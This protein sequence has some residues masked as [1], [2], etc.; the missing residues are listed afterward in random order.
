[1]EN[2]MKLL[3]TTLLFALLTSCVTNEELPSEHI[4]TD[5]SIDGRWY[6]VSR[7]HMY[8]DY[9]EE[10]I[11]GKQESY[12]FSYSDSLITYYGYDSSDILSD[13]GESLIENT[14]FGQVTNRL[15]LDDTLCFI[16][17]KGEHQYREKALQLENNWSELAWLYDKYTPIQDTVDTPEKMIGTWYLAYKDTVTLTDVPE[18]TSTSFSNVDE[19]NAIYRITTDSVTC[20]T[21]QGDYK[22]D[23]VNTFAGVH[24]F[25]TQ[26]TV[27]EDSLIITHFA[28][29]NY[30]NFITTVLIKHSGPTPP[31]S[32]IIEPYLDKA[33]TLNINEPE[34]GGFNAPSD[35]K[36]Y[37]FTASR[38]GVYSL[39]F[40]NVFGYAQLFTSNDNGEEL[41]SDFIYDNQ[42]IDVECEKGVTYYFSLR[43][44]YEVMS[45]Y[46]LELTEK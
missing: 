37:Q 44:E 18:T 35:G 8:K 20:F 12:V 32:W 27:K 25:I 11:L 46:T 38:N 2:N 26:G 14:F 29:N 24:S 1:M 3:L 13:S 31:R 42:S 22:V 10:H 45:N 5:K 19:S 34:S 40:S 15:F 30:N 41:S 4:P 23:S 21:A 33:D 36:T 43:A 28:E 17:E 7:E 16:I 39:V 9:S 6:V